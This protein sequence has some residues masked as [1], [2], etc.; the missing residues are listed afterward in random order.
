M[1]VGYVGKLL[2]AKEQS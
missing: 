2:H 1:I